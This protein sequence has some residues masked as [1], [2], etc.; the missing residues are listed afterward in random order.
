VRE[1]V[2]VSDAAH[3]KPRSRLLQS[4]HDG[5]ALGGAAIAMVRRQ[6]G[7]RRYLGWAFVVLLVVHL[8]VAAAILHY[9]HHGTIPQ[10]LIVVL[11]TGYVVAVL[12]NAAAVGLAGLSDSILSGRP[13]AA[14]DGWRL[15]LQRLPQVAG[16][17][18]VVLAV[19]VPARLLTSWGVDQLA[20]V[21]LGFGWGVLSFFAVPAIALTAAGPIAAAERSFHLVKRFWAGQV[22]GMVYIWLQP[23]LFIGL[24]GAAA[25]LTGVVLERSGHDLLGWAI[26]LGG[27]VA[28]AVAYL[29]M[30]SAKS[31][32][33]VAIFR[34]AEDGEAPPGFDGERLRRMLVGPTSFVE[35]IARRLDNDRVR[36]LRKRL[37]EARERV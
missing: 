37:A 21:L 29:I 12:S 5:W 14:R 25:L 32:L 8:A 35:R 26:A 33:S 13:A 36:R 30:V 9:R 3:P 2:G 22:A 28:L 17:G 16:W 6:P 15:T 4:A 31:I 24:P 1:H 27:A 20:A 10:R 11:I 19:G 23:V 18:L 7:L 34:F